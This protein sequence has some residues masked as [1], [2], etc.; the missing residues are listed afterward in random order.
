MI[1][2]KSIINKQENEDSSCSNNN[3]KFRS[4]TNL[5]DFS[6]S[7]NSKSKIL[8]E[9]NQSGV[10]IPAKKFQSKRN[11]DKQLL[12]ND[13]NFLSHLNIRNNFYNFNENIFSSTH[14]TKSINSVSLKSIEK[15]LQQRIFNISMKIEKESTVIG[16]LNDDNIKLT[17]LIKKKIV[18]KDNVSIFSPKHNKKIQN[19][20]EKIVFFDNIKEKEI[21]SPKHNKPK[22]KVKKTLK[23][24]KNKFRKL[25]KKNLIYDSFD[26][27]EEEEELEG[28][29]IPP[30]NSFIL[31]I[32][33]LI[34]ISSLF[35]MIYTPYYISNFKLICNTTKSCRYFYYFIDLLYIMDLILGFFRAHH[36]YQFQIIKNN[37]EI[38]KHYL[39]TQMF[40]DLIQAVPFFSYIY[41]LQDKNIL[42]YCEYYRVN[43]FHLIL[44]LCCNLKY[45]KFFKV[46]DIKKNSIFYK[47]KQF[48]SKNDHSEKIFT[49]LLYFILCIFGFNFFIS[50]HI[51]IG[52]SSYPNWII[53]FDFQEENL[54]SLYLISFYYIIT[55]TTTVG[56]GNIVCASSFRELMFQIILLSV[57]ITVYSWIVSNIGNYVKNESSASIRFD[58]DE[59]ILEEIRILYPNISYSLY[60]KIFNHLGVRKIRQRQC[61][62]N[63]LINSLP[64][65]LKTEILLSIH[66]KTINNFKIFRG[67]QN[68]DFTV[69]LL[70]NFIPLFSKKNA[71]LIHEGQLIN[72]I[73]FVKEGSLALEACIDINEPYKSVKKYLN[74]NFGDIFEDAVIVSDY[75]DSF[76]VTKITGNNYNNIFNKAKNE[77]NSLINDNNNEHDESINESIII[78][79]IGKWDYGGEVFEES[80]HQLINI[81]NISKNENFGEVYMFLSKPSPL[82][83]R[84]RSKKAELYL[85]RKYDVSDISIRYPNIWAKFFKKSYLNMLTIKSLTIQKIKYYWKNLGKHITKKNKINENTFDLSIKPQKSKSN[86]VRTIIPKICINGANIKNNDS[87]NKLLDNEN[88]NSFKYSKFGEKSSFRNIQ[89]KESIKYISFAKDNSNKYLD[90]KYRSCYN[91]NRINIQDDIKNEKNDRR[92]VRTY[93]NKNNLKLS[94]FKSDYKNVLNND[95]NNKNSDNK[96][97]SIKELRLDYLNKLKNKIKKLK[98]SKK[99]YKNLWK[100]LSCNT[101]KNLPKKNNN[102]NNSL[103]MDNINNIEEKSEKKTH[104]SEKINNININI[105]FNNNNVILDKQEINISK[106]SNHSNS[107]SS[108]KSKAFI[109]NDLSITSPINFSLMEKYVNLEKLTKGEYSKNY[110]LRKITQKFIQFY[111]STFSHNIKKENISNPNLSTIRP[112]LNNKLNLDKPIYTSL[113]SDKKQINTPKKKSSNFSFNNSSLIKAYPNFNDKKIIIIYDTYNNYFYLYGNNI[114]K[115]RFSASECKIYDTNGSKMK[116]CMNFFKNDYYN[117][118]NSKKDFLNNNINKESFFDNKRVNNILFNNNNN[119]CKKNI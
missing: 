79:E 57:G 95:D 37:M 42:K 72:N 86:I 16:V 111:I 101:Q 73:I 70:T 28:I 6:N 43:S 30:D 53:N 98:I 62:S 118:N 106:I 113:F 67:N 2:I 21:I 60:K 18:D 81:I 26:S 22:L 34:I 87:N 12:S 23:N 9:L 51:L 41:F 74:K 11:L 14:L 36:N 69:R 39:V 65:S 92:N 32:D 105:N 48:I 88:D 103:K 19:C 97:E 119:K 91:E 17:A 25:L 109:N 13:N 117:N 44:I 24:N 96:R 89:N 52:R 75:N 1:K 71:F 55:T 93:L 63:I 7:H 20:P 54:L 29:I 47:I 38:I 45:L 76:D 56:Y 46:I 115:K 108:S 61:D 27:T 8:K 80:N 114:D 10:I 33:L 102:L 110:N 116:L 50:I 100:E 90:V 64:H 68:T 49:F 83:L 84:V 85:L 40:L 104:N 77:L 3:K 99:Y 4:L 112:Q 5:E 78:K 58:K 82:S 31:V 66:K 94:K 107:S 59:A 15:D 35:N